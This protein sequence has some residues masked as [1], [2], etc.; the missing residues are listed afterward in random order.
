M[1]LTLGG[2]AIKPRVTLRQDQVVLAVPPDDVLVHLR[3]RFSQGP[4][5]VAA[6][7]NRVVRHFSGR[8]GPFPYRT[9][10]IVSFEPG[11]ITF[12]HLQGPFAACHERFDLTLTSTDTRLTHSGSFRL[13][14]G[15]WTWPLAVGPI[16]RAF[17]D[18][19]AEHLRR[20]RD[21]LA[22]TN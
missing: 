14:G 7:S 21:E 13:R 6:D 11:A 18:H 17:E 16:K 4:G 1:A 20:L 10:E 19:V 2:I 22:P 12:E 5:V 3:E 15:I 9:V 8:A